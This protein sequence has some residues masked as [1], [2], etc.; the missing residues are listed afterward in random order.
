[1]NIFTD[2]TLEGTESLSSGAVSMLS[3]SPIDLTN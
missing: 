1:M 3:H 2:E